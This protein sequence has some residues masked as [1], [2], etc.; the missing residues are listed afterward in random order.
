[1]VNNQLLPSKYVLFNNN[2]YDLNIV[3]K[4]FS[5]S[6]KAM[7]EFEMGGAGNYCGGGG[8]DPI[9]LIP[10]YDEFIPSSHISG[11]AGIFYALTQITEADK[12]SLLNL[13]DLNNV[14]IDEDMLQF[15]RDVE[16]QYITT[17]YAS[18]FNL[19]LYSFSNLQDPTLISCDKNLNVFANQDLDIRSDNRI[20]FSIVADP[21][22]LKRPAF[23]RLLNYPT[24]FIKLMIAIN[25][26]LCKFAGFTDLGNKSHLTIYDVN[27]I[28]RIMTGMNLI[29]DQYTTNGYRS[30][31]KS[32]Y[33]NIYNPYANSGLYNSPNNSIDYGMK[34]VQTLGIIALQKQ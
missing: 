25:S 10:P 30:N 22:L 3:P 26:S 8:E 2:A 1:M 23:E 29:N 4:R 9:L 6:Y 18:F 20:R 15:I 12:R 5:L 28:Y 7:N 16:Y 13:N 24:V 33:S 21:S 32:N 27:K 19:S 17:T 11:T 34:T 14:M 31:L